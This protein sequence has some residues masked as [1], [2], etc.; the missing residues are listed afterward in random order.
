MAKKNKLTGYAAYYEI[1]TITSGAWY[2]PITARTERDIR[3]EAKRRL[4]KRQKE[5]GNK[6]LVHL[7]GTFFEQG[8][9]S[10]QV[11][12][13]NDYLEGKMYTW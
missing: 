10:A 5:I 7:I 3:E 1:G 6:G 2:E 4:D 12:R 8:S 13:Q 9:A 11:A